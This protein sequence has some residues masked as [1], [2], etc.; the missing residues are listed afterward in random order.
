M[1]RNLDRRKSPGVRDFGRLELPTPSVSTLDNGVRLTILDRG[2]QD[3]NRVSIVCCGGSTEAPS[4]AIATIMPELMREGTSMMTGREIAEIMDMNGAWLKTV[5][6]SH[7]TAMVLHSL[8]SRFNDVL[9]MMASMLFQPTFPQKELDILTEKAACKIEIEQKKMSYLAAKE[10]TRLLAGPGHH[11]SRFE[12]PE[13]I[14]AISRDEILSWHRLCATTYGINVFATGRI[15]AKMENHL[16]NT[17]S[18]LKPGADCVKINETPFSPQKPPDTVIIKRPDSMQSAIKMAIP[19]IGRQHPDYVPLRLTVMALG[20]YFGSRLMLN[21][22]EDKGYTYGIGAALL[23]Y[24]NESTIEIST[25][26]ANRYVPSVIEEVKTEL[27]RIKK[28]ETFTDDEM[29]RMRR[30]AMTV[31]ASTLDTP[32]S[33]MDYYETALYAATPPDYFRQ[34][35]DAIVSLTPDIIATMARRYFNQ[36]HMYTVIAGNPDGY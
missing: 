11:L 18:Q 36:E 13:D 31:L 10:M 23:G 28:Q 2:Q 27:E 16:I 7:H 26:C 34:Q 6:H 8:N 20:G 25:E 12:T 21:I 15:T 5:T 30:H 35:Y 24:R 17:L 3:I 33:V 9:D 29:E 22:R 1:C 14:R 32:F 4:P 19:S